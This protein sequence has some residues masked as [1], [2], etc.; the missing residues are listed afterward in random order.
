MLVC[1]Y[2]NFFARQPRT[3]S[4]PAQTVHKPSSYHKVAKGMKQESN[5]GGRRNVMTDRM[6]LI[7]FGL[8]AIY[9]LLD[10]FLSIFLSYD[11][12]LE[13]MLGVQLENI[14]GRI[15]VLCMFV[16]FGSH[17]Q[18]TMDERKKAAAKMERDAATRE[19]FQ[20]LLSPD[21]AE[22]VVSGA[23]TVQKGGEGR[24][25]TV[26]FIDIRGFTALSSKTNAAD[27][28]QLLNEYYEVVV[29]VVFR[30]EGT[31]DKF[32]GDGMMVIWGAPVSHLDDPHRAVRAALEI[33]KA[34][35]DFNYYRLARGAAP[36]AVG[37][38][39]NTGPVVAGY[40]GSS[41]TMSYSVIGDTVNMAARLCGTAK[42]GQIVI[43]EE[44]RR[45]VAEAFRT[46]AVGPFTVKGRR[47]TIRAYAVIG[48]DEVKVTTAQAATLES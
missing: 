8:A 48:S 11:H 24:I 35:E 2:A 13:R 36:I 42:P 23:L 34:L 27:I 41:R 33:M 28:L 47:D 1:I 7:G 38:G 9:W 12:F 21:L 40:L 29:E 31:V 22:M 17:A 5:T 37:I 46:K 16:I 43:S 4:L 14:W 44:T 3:G 30:H 10:S 15:I 32:I 19:R 18:F 25:A 26:M 39:V 6:V 20:R 45:L